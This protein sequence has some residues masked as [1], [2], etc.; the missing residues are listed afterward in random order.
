MRKRLLLVATLGVLAVVPTP[1]SAHGLGPAHPNVGSSLGIRIIMRDG[2]EV[3]HHQNQAARH[4]RPQ[5]WPRRFSNHAP[6][7]RW[8]GPWQHR[9]P[10]YHWR[11]REHRPWFRAPGGPHFKDSHAKQWLHAPWQHGRPALRN[12]SPHARFKHG[13]RRSGPRRHH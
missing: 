3:V 13:H 10:Q 2:P 9:P 12:D 1:A 4:L 8:R 5:P 7:W 6:A 11:D